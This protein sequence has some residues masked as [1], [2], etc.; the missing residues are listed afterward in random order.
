[1][2][3]WRAVVAAEPDFATQGRPL[4]DVP[5]HKTLATLRRDGSPRTSGIEAR[6]GDDELRRA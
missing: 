5:K 6:F 4:F 2:V 3:S 1:M